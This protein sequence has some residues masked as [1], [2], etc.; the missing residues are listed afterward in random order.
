MNGDVS[1]SLLFFEFVFHQAPQDRKTLFAPQSP[2]PSQ[3]HA[4]ISWLTIPNNC[5][6]VGL[7]GLPF[8]EQL[9][10]NSWTVHERRCISL[11][12]SLRVCP[13]FFKPRHRRKHHF[14][15]PLVPWPKT[16]PEKDSWTKTENDP[17]KRFMNKLHEQLLNKIHERVLQKNT[18][19]VTSGEKDLWTTAVWWKRFMNG[20]VAF[21]F[22]YER[23]RPG[24]KVSTFFAH[25][26]IIFINFGANYKKSISIKFI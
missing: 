22:L 23:R 13:S 2:T 8:H 4:M 12:C 25:D 20:S 10:N 7:L 16:T 24:W 17:W 11:N 3:P 19:S 1:R 9:M 15:L 21:F 26:N 5:S 18:A 14:P 6:R